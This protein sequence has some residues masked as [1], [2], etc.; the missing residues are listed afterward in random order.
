MVVHTIT[1]KNMM[2]N[3]RLFSMNREFMSLGF[4]MNK[5]GL[6]SMELSVKSF[7]WV[8]R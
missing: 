1:K 3:V 2:N 5:Y 6:T 8:K 4:I 7:V